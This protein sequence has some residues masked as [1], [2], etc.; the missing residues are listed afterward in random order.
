MTQPSVGEEGEVEKDGRDAAACD[1]QRLKLGGTNIADV[2]NVLVGSHGRVV[3]SMRVDD[4]VQE[5]PQEHPQP[6][7]A[8]DDGEDL[9]DSCQY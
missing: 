6:D 1:K 7:E 2:G 3:R 9:D 5:Q 8:G 4:P